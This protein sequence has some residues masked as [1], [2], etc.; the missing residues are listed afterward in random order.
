S[1]KE[2]HA[3]LADS[4]FFLPVESAAPRDVPRSTVSAAGGASVLK[5]LRLC[6]EAAIAE[7]IDAICFAPLNKQSMKLS[8]L[9]FSDELHFFAHHLKVSSYVCEFNTLGTLWTSRIT[10]H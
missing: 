4:P 9:P 3:K 5:I 7:E 1:F 8:G 10:S 2:A 6:L